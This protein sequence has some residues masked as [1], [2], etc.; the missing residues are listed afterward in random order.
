MIYRLEWSTIC[1]V[2]RFRAEGAFPLKQ[3]TYSV[4]KKVCPT[5]Y[6]DIY[7]YNAR[8]AVWESG[9]G[10]SQQFSTT[11]KF[12]G[13]C[14]GIKEPRFWFLW[15][16]HCGKCVTHIQYWSEKLEKSKNRDSENESLVR[17]G[18]L[19]SFPGWYWAVLGWFWCFPVMWDAFSGVWISSWTRNFHGQ[20]LGWSEFGWI[21]LG[22]Y[23]APSAPTMPRGLV[24][25]I[26][27][28]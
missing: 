18:G 15:A 28:A 25:V 12:F 3:I 6:I 20:D 24:L 10:A 8:V 11:Q 27:T 26:S 23:V 21:R 16:S 17:S 19:R 9:W 5:G 22:E 4:S 2:F 14:L 7:I 1:E 13:T